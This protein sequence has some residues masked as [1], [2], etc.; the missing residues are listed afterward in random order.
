[1]LAG[2]DDPL[3]AITRGRK[4]R[5]D[6]FRIRDTGVCSGVEVLNFITKLYDSFQVKGLKVRTKLYH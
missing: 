6:S 4:Y 5:F 3:P 2:T 1:M